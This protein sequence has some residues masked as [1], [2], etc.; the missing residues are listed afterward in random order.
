VVGVE[1]MAGQWGEGAPALA[2]GGGGGVRGVEKSWIH[3]FSGL[4]FSSLLRSC[5]ALSLEQCNCTCKCQEF[6]RLSKTLVCLSRMNKFLHHA[7]HV[8][9]GDHKGMFRRLKILI[10]ALAIAIKATLH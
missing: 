2:R 7:F 6:Q 1:G 10:L 8:F 5:S 3:D 4:L 9:Q